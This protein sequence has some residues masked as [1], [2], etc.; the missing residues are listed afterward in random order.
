[1]EKKYGSAANVMKFL[2]LEFIFNSSNAKR[3]FGFD[4]VLDDSTQLREI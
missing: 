1:M 2:M 4:E 3:F